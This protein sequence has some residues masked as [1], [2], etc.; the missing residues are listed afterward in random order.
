[1]AAQIVEFVVID[2]DTIQQDFTVPMVVKTGYQTDQCGFT[3]AGLSDRILFLPEVP[4]LEMAGFYQV[5]DLYVAPQRWEGFGLTPLEAMSCGAPVVATRVG[6]FEELVAEGETGTLVDPGDIDAMTVA[7]DAAL[8]DPGRLAQ[9]STAAR[10]RVLAQFKLQQE[11]DALIAIY[12]WLL[13]D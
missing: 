5:L 6:A 8:S 4:V 11:A 2:V 7:V 10:D 13:S 1:M 3:A 9:W 12:R